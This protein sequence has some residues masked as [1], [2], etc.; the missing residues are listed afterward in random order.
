[1]REQRKQSTD[2]WLA[3]KL[4]IVIVSR[5]LNATV[6]LPDY[7][8]LHAFPTDGYIDAHDLQTLDRVFTIT[9]TPNC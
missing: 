5:E 8:L 1:M 7:F 6:L 4:G 2:V 9:G 3:N